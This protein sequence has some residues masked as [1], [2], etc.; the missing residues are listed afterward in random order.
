MVASYHFVA[1][2]GGP[3]HSQRDIAKCLNLLNVEDSYKK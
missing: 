2:D 1:F 3:V